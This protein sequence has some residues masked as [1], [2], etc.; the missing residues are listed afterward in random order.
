MDPKQKTR[1]YKIIF[2]EQTEQKDMCNED[3]TRFQQTRLRHMR[4]S[5]FFE[6]YYP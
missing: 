1:N 3:N 2:F 4:V 5:S 6:C